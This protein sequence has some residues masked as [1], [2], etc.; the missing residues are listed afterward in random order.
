MRVGISGLRVADDDPG[1]LCV[2]SFSA[3]RCAGRR[4]QQDRTSA[5][6]GGHGG[7]TEKV[8]DLSTFLREMPQIVAFMGYLLIDFMGQG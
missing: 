7:V 4:D 5:Q 6:P 8:D 1:R 2:I 3:N